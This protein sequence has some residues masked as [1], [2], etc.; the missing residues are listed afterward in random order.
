[1]EKVKKWRL[2]AIEA[3]KQCGAAWL[4]HV[5]LPMTLKQFVAR[6]EKLDLALVGSLQPDVRHPRECIRKYDAQYGALPR[7]VAVW[8]GPE[9]DF[10]LEELHAIQ[11]TGAQP[12]SLGSLVLRVETAAIY[13]L[14]FLNYELGAK[15]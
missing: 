4:P 1:M 6:Q 5:D 15:Q 2:V 10:T 3:I 9:G 8:I 13:C 12:I 7:S 11:A 14:S